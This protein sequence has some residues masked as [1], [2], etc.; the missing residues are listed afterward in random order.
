V[1]FVRDLRES[2]QA[3]A[4]MDCQRIVIVIVVNAD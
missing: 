4:V 3:F 1:V 2:R